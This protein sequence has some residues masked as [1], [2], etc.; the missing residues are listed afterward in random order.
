[1]SRRVSSFRLAA[2]AACVASASP[3]TFAQSVR[4]VDVD[5]L[6]T[7]PDVGTS[8]AKAFNSLQ[9]ALA[10]AAP[11]D[12]IWVKA[13]TY[14]PDDGGLQTPGDRQAT[15]QLITGVAVYGGF[16]GD[17]TL[18]EQ[19]DPNTHLTILSGDLQSDDVANLADF[20]PCRIAPYGGPLPPECAPFDANADNNIFANE[21]NMDDNSFHVVTGSGTDASAVLDGFLITAGNAD[22]FGS[23]TDRGGGL[24]IVSG[25]PTISSCSFISN[26]AQYGGGA[27]NERGSPAISGCTFSGNVTGQ[28]GGG[29]YSLGFS[30]GNP[31]VINCQ[32]VGNSSPFGGGMYVRDMET[33]TITNCMFSGNVAPDL[34][35]SSG[36]G[37]GLHVV[38]GTPVVT[39]CS[40]SGNTA[41]NGGA[42][43]N[44][45][46]GSNPSLPILTNCV[47]WGNSATVSGQQI[48]NF[49]STPTISF[50]D[51]EG[52]GGSGGGWDTALGN[53][54]GGNIDADPL[55]VDADGADNVAGTLDDN[56]RLK[57]GSP[58][59]DAG[60]NSAVA[61]SI[62]TDLDGQPRIQCESV[63]MGAYES[64]LGTGGVVITCPVDVLLAC[65]ADTS[66]G[67]TGSATAIDD[68]SGENF[69]ITSSDAVVS[70][71]GDTKIITRTWTADD[72]SGDP[73]SC[74]QTIN[75]QDTTD[76]VFNTFPANASLECPVADTSP[77]TT[78][79]PTG[80]DNCGNV[81]I[82]SSDS[83]VA[84]CGST[85]T[86]TRTW[87]IADECGNGISQDQTIEV[88]DT[89]P[90][91]L[92]IPVDVTIQ[93]DASSAPTDTGQAT[94][95]DDCDVAPSIAHNDDTSGLTGCNGTGTLVR[96]WTATD[97]CSNSVSDT[98]FITIVDTTNPSI[99]CPV[100][101]TLE[102][103]ADT[104]VAANGSAT[105]TDACGSVAI[106]SSDGSVSNCGNTETI[107]RTW[108]ATDDCGS[109][110]TCDQT[111]TVVDTTSPVLTIPADVTIE[112]DASSAPTNTGQATAT[113]NCDP[114]SGVTFSDSVA[115]GTCPQESAITRTWT[116]TDECG[117]SASADQ[118][119]TVEDTTSPVITCPEDIFTGG[120][121]GAVVDIDPFPSATDN[122]DP[123]PDVT[124]NPA[125]G[126]FFSTGVTTVTATARD[127]CAN[128]APCTFD[129]LVSCFAVNRVKIGT[130]DDKCKGVAF[131]EITST[132]GMDQLIGVYVPEEGQ[133]KLSSKTIVDDGVNGPQ[134][135]HT[136]CSQPIEIGDVFGA[137][138]VTDLIKIF[139]DDPDSRGNKV[140][141]RGTFDPVLP[142]DPVVDDVTFTV[143]DGQGHM[144]TFFIP[145][146]SFEVDGKPEKRKFKF[147]S[148]PGSDMDIKAKF[149]LGRCKFK[150][151]VKGV[152]DTSQIVGT[153]LTVTLQVGAN[154]AQEDIEMVDKRNHLEHKKSPK[155]ECC[156]RCDG[157]A[158]MQVTSDQGVLL[159]EPEPGR[160]ELRSNT[161]VDD[162]VN[163]PQEIHTSCSQALDVGDVFGPYTVSE[164]VKIFE[165]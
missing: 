70:G 144:F 33:M 99:T 96:T 112:C 30:S 108:T 164:L 129:V 93:C 12:E 11:G 136:S 165:E 89:T 147:H 1:M 154:V 90:P 117:N 7:P 139:H 104:S 94:A 19:R 103:P 27:F 38:V 160:D 35:G 138:T 97:A 116:T 52:S 42:M 37:G 47:F 61:P 150:L 55:F 4:Y 67:A 72:G 151:N 43:R 115:P 74:V 64:S 9:D 45:K 79:S 51:I 16:A 76:P 141:I 152:Q 163:G 149:E 146:G 127:A 54:G 145:A 81:T 143:D 22:I 49:S 29:L 63:D 2:F 125:S 66:V 3:A 133:E 62:T 69:T 15:F 73:A 142:I 148:A 20:L 46:S 114:A 135:I 86:I 156:P 113:D 56:L 82:S 85:E 18:R 120:F 6:A 50:C 24:L 121:D 31:T 92:T 57:A 101:A 126:S 36:S 32:F 84:G 39:N 59:I 58:C 65:P 123:P 130:K 91:V 102:C 88:V 128:S 87:S 23:P 53:D 100:D 118:I 83:S 77:A 153:S 34:G 159:F 60:N 13:G 78:G 134:E 68:C 119:I 124:T 110:T 26:F 98:Q 137:Y 10:T 106:A 8:W 107:T 109:F 71:C 40:F 132:H 5:S 28:Q 105:G 158:F 122:C 44:V 131:L 161:V 48:G 14:K 111:I 21:L 95:T 157:I 17:E 155:L 41:K 80:S 75:V 162:G 140:E 25:S